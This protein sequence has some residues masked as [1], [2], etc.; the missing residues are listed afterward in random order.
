MDT[1]SFYCILYIAVFNEMIFIKKIHTSD[2]TN[3]DVFID[4]MIRTKKISIDIYQMATR[5]LLLI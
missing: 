1:M 5:L 2:S 4:E 3:W